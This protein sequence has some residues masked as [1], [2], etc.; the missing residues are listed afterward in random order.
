MTMTDVDF[1]VVGA[2]FAGLTAAL[3][4]HQAGSSVLLLEAR[5]RPGGRTFTEVRDDG[6]YIDHGGTWIGPGQDRVYAMMSDLG[7]E[8]Y[9]QYTDAEA[10]MLLDGKIYRYGGLIAWSMNPLTSVNLGTALLE[11]Q[12]MC[13][14]I[15]LEAPWTAP[16]ADKW[17][18]M[19]LA[20]WLDQHVPTKQAR[21][22]LEM[23]LAGA[24]TSAASELSM[25]FVAYQ[26]A[27]AGGP[28]F[29]LGVRD[30]AEDA[31]PVGGMG[32]IYHAIADRLAG[33]IQYQQPVRTIR[34]DADGVTVRSATSEVRA[35]RVVVAVPI[36]IAS[37]IIYEPILP[38]DRAL[39]HQRMPTG[40]IIKCHA[41]YDEPFWRNDGLT[42]QTAAPGTAAAVTLDACMHQGGPG[43]LCII[44]EGS[45]ARRLSQLAPADRQAAM[46][47]AL[48]E[49][50]GPKA[51]SPFD[52][53]QQDWTAE[54]YSGGAMISHTPPGVLTQ[55]GHALRQPCGRIHWAGTET[56]TVMY[57][58]VDGA[59]RSGERAAEEALA[60]DAAGQLTATG[61]T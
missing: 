53:T 42:G 18:R 20:Q 37:Q 3:R 34:Q 39:L 5:D 30:A 38:V 19:T 55:Y 40:A 57:G 44:N 12:K 4:L 32:A 45:H 52:F 15:P 46:L 28:N 11:L 59:I 31:R 29:V 13:K 21:Q 1:C 35:S 27:T 51:K 2:G 61:M 58:F 48:A 10:M 49:R 24:Y 54:P 36:A 22:M 7:I 9:K 26:L 60:A 8:P 25:L 16:K 23:A 14:T 47:D 43:V 41:L 17:D 33:V 50:F 6:T 56:S